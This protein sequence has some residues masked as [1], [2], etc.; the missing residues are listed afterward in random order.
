MRQHIFFLRFLTKEEKLTQ[1][2]NLQRT[3]EYVNIFVVA[4]SLIL[5]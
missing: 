1:T 2:E 5:C 3:N 4:I